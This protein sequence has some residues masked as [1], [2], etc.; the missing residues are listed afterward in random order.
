LLSNFQFYLT[1]YFYL[2]K[3]NKEIKLLGVRHF[4]DLLG[5]CVSRRYILRIKTEAN[6]PT[7]LKTYGDDDDD[8][9]DGAERL[10]E[11]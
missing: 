10:V 2:P 4:F 3:L 5:I 7:P 6:S 9:H 1:T 8:G 11:H